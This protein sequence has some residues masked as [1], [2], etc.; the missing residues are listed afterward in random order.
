MVTLFTSKYVEFFYGYLD[1][2]IGEVIRN[3]CY[4]NNPSRSSVRRSVIDLIRDDVEVEDEEE[5][6]GRKRHISFENVHSL[7]RDDIEFENKKNRSVTESDSPLPAAAKIPV[8]MGTH[9]TFVSVDKSDLSPKEIKKSGDENLKAP[10]TDSKA[11]SRSHTNMKGESP[12]GARKVS[13]PPVQISKGV[14]PKKS[15]TPIGL[16]VPLPDDSSSTSP[17]PINISPLSP[18]PSS[19]LFPFLSPPQSPLIEEIDG[20]SRVTDNTKVD[21]FAIREIINSIFRS[22]DAVPEPLRRVMR[23]IKEEADEVTGGKGA[24]VVACFLILRIIT[25]A[26]FCRKWKIRV[27]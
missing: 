5:L 14:S 20:D 16:D 8:D 6:D 24:R 18:S 2:T 23:A 19:P 7:N 25:P 26:H 21:L 9:L 15:G 17:Q 27:F 11:K 22:P 10:Q 4:M 1:S 3:L 13:A 12:L